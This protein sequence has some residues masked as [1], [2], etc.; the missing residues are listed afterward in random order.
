MASRQAVG[1]DPEA[2][3]ALIE[4]FADRTLSEAEMEAAFARLDAALD[5]TRREDRERP[6]A[7]P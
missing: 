6:D 7:A 2:P 3:D 5:T 4:E 1:E